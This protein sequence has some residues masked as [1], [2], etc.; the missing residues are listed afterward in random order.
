M[1]YTWKAS[2]IAAL[3][4][5]QP[6]LLRGRI[7][8]AADAIEKRLLRPIEFGSDEDKELREA[9]RILGVLKQQL[10]S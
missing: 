7:L 2:Y 5:M 9:R 1:P 6:K 3:C 8:D 10:S 4:E